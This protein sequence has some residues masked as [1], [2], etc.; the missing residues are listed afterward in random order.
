MGRWERGVELGE[1]HTRVCIRAASRDGGVSVGVECDQSVS[2][3]ASSA[4]LDRWG[5]GQSVLAAGGG[6][7]VPTRACSIAVCI[8]SV[9]AREGDHSRVRASI[10][11]PLLHARIT[12]W[13]TT[14]QRAAK[15][16]RTNAHNIPA[17]AGVV[18]QRTLSDARVCTHSRDA[19]TRYSRLAPIADGKILLVIAHKLGKF[20]FLLC[21][22]LAIVLQRLGRGRWERIL[23]PLPCLARIRFWRASI[24][25]FPP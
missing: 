14:T 2:E 21:S 7:G 16:E 17:V 18:P 5:C 20:S 10:R 9:R 3:Q 22:H 12:R 13:A 15:Y 23:V 25:D 24:P 11:H 4:R 19:S 6:I 1:C 8:L